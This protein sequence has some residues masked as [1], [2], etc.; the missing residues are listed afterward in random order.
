MSWS[1]ILRKAPHRTARN[2][3]VKD[4]EMPIAVIQNEEYAD[5]IIPKRSW[6]CRVAWWR[7]YKEH[8]INSVQASNELRPL[9]HQAKSAMQLQLPPNHWGS[10]KF[11][12]STT[13]PLAITLC[14]EI[15]SHQR[16][17][18]SHC[19][20]NDQ[21]FNQKVVKG[22]ANSISIKKILLDLLC[23]GSESACSKIFS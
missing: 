1:G 14:C 15:D 19:T 23:L 6:N 9:L 12:P 16:P 18:L 20:E 17:T 21:N 10:P 22:S 5:W 8:C 7:G 13:K 11:Q 3:D 2:V 4:L